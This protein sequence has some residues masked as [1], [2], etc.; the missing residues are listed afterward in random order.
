M[1]GLPTPVAVVCDGLIQ[2]IL[3][4]FDTTL[5]I[6]IRICRAGC[7]CTTQSHQDPK[8]DSYQRESGLHGDLHGSPKT[9]W[10]VSPARLPSIGDGRAQRQVARMRVPLNYG[11]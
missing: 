6:P 10:V 11:N 9:C 3:Q 5:A 1:I 8:C 2:L 7:A 4:M